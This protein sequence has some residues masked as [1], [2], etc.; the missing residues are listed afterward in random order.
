MK[1]VFSPG[2]GH[3]VLRILLVVVENVHSRGIAVR[4]HL[5]CHDGRRRVP[6]VLISKQA[7]LCVVKGLAVKLLLQIEIYLKHKRR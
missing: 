5:Q 2:H 4:G 1:E 7:H 6:A 3:M